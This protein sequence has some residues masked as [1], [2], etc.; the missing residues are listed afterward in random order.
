MRLIPA[1]IAMLA[2]ASSLPA[3]ATLPEVSAHLAATRTMTAD[4][5]QTAENGG[6]ATGTLTLARPGRV[7]FQ[8][9]KDV[10][11]LVVAD[12]KSLAMID[13]EVAQ[14][15]RYPIRQTP[16]GVLLDAEADLS[17]YVRVVSSTPQALTVEAKD[18]KHPEYGTITIFFARSRSA[19]AGLALTG[20]RV[21][22]AQGNR[23]DIALSNVAFNVPI[24]DN[25]FRF[26]DPRRRVRPGA[27]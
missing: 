27:H 24:A 10:P 17:K 25:A 11:L 1:M 23:T 3:R 2:A 26:K 12:G 5:R 6:V 19:P 22:D 20:W 4:F 13:Y 18:R 15:S 14:V 21:L 9:Q 16:L 7:R 8:Y